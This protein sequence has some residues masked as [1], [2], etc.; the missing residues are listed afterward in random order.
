MKCFKG[1]LHIVVL[2]L[3]LSTLS[4]RNEAAAV[5][6]QENKAKS[7]ASEP[8][9]NPAIN[10]PA[11]SADSAFKRI[12]EQCDFGARVP[13]SA[14]HVNCAKYLG[15]KLAEYGAEVEIQTFSATAF[16]GKVLAGKNVIGC[17]SP[18]K[19]RRI[20]LFSHWD[21]RPFCDQDE[22]QYRDIPVMGANDGASG[23]GVILEIARLINLQKPNVGVDIVFLDAEDYGDATGESSDS[24]C[25]G[26]QYW[27][28]HPHYK[29]KP[30][31]GILLDMVGGE[32]PYFGIDAATAQ[33]AGNE[34]GKVWS[35]ANSLGYREYF[36][37]RTTS[38]L[39][40]DHVYINQFTGI[41]T[42]DIIDFNPNKGFPDVW[43]THN[44]TPENISKST[45]D[46]VGKT[47][48]QLIY[49][50]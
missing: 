50:E 34:A 36:Q 46:M 31:Y 28:R 30:I 12:C 23:V 6:Q 39:I 11:F 8:S 42:I 49:R 18:E 45:L 24:W 19:G 48:I 41:P 10:I 5:Q 21:S 14:A 1:I 37:P 29:K 13:N 15:D 38:R 33:Y 7:A 20:I 25:L 47:L 26:S 9:A 32:H 2:L 27:G 17:F 4:C 16:D 44:D 40:D 43:H 22:P 3:S 35:I